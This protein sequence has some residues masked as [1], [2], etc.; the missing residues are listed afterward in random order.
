[1]KTEP[2]RSTLAS[3]IRDA[4]KAR[5]FSQGDVAERVGVSIEAVSGWEKDKYVPSTDNL[6]ALAQVLETSVDKL[7]S[8]KSTFREEDRIFDENHMSTFLKARFTVGD[9]KMSSE[10]LAFAKK[11]HEGQFRDRKKTVPYI[12]HPLTMACQAFALVDYKL[13]K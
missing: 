9:W 6:Q 2:Q 4:R 3:N 10:A 8:A 7:L 11:H 5:H 13:N 12:N 1:V